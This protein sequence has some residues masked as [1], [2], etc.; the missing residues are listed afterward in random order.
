M[1]LHTTTCSSRLLN[2]LNVINMSWQISQNK[3]LTVPPQKRARFELQQ[4][5]FIQS[6]SP[7]LLFGAHI[8]THDLYDYMGY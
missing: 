2:F 7:R 3:I 6:S 5:F 1:S 8:A 4:R